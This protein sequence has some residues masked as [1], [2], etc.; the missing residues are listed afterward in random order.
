MLSLTA[1]G[2]LTVL[3]SVGPLNDRAP[4]PALVYAQDISFA[5]TSA[6]HGVTED[7]C[8]FSSTGW[9]SS[10]GVVVFYKIYYCKSPAHAQ[11]VLNKLTKDASKIFEKKNLNKGRKKT[12]ERVVASF[13]KEPTIKPEMILWTDGGEIHM[14]ES[15]SFSHALLFEKKLPSV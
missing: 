5:E 10:D 4:K 13:T 15:T 12:G 9:Q 11:E 6:V 8:E 7:G 3:I 1:L 2:L 14:V